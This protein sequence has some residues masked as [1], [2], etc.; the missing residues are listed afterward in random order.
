MAETNSISYDNATQDSWDDPG[1]LLDEQ[2]AHVDS[3]SYDNGTLESWD[4]PSI[5]L[6]ANS[7]FNPNAFGEVRAEICDVYVYTV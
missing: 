6:L 4:N 5:A 3:I 7:T 2:M 1:N